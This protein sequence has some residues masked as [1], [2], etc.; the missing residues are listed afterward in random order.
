MHTRD[1]RVGEGRSR[2]GQ[3]GRDGQREVERGREG[4]RDRQIPTAHWLFSVPA[5]RVSDQRDPMSKKQN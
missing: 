3:R 5:C 4:Q 1:P 2:E